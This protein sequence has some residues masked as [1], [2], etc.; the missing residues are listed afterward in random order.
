MEGPAPVWFAL[1]G[2]KP[3]L[4]FSGAVIAMWPLSP[5]LWQFPIVG[6]AKRESVAARATGSCVRK[7]CGS[8]PV[9]RLNSRDAASVAALRVRG[10]SGRLL[11]RCADGAGLLA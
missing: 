3:D 6:V 1:L 9:R 8:A 10:G 5:P 2:G 4:R 11:L 7:L